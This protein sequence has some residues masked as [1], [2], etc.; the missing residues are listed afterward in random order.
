MELLGHL[1]VARLADLECCRD[2]I[3]DLLT[4]HGVLLPDDLRQRLD[5]FKG[6][7]E[8]AIEDHARM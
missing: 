2:L 4:D 8:A 3:D 7:V 5:T 6:D 1:A